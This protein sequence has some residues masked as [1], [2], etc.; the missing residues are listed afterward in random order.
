LHNYVL[1]KADLHILP[2]AQFVKL[3]GNTF[4]IFCVIGDFFEIPFFP[5]SSVLIFDHFLTELNK[6]FAKAYK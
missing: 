1:Q 5:G 4:K 3:A 6:L 2:N